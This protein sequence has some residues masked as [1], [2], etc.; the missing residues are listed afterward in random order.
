LFDLF[1][2]TNFSSHD[3]GID[4]KLYVNDKLVCTSNA[5]YGG[6]RASEA[7]IAGEKWETITSYTACDRPIAITK[8]DKLKMSSIYDLT[9]HKL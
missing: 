5:V 6:Y 3:G 1:L 7:N 8:G 9:K 2:A 4:V